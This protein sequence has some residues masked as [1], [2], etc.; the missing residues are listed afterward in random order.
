MTAFAELRCALL[1]LTLVL[2][3][4]APAGAAPVPGT[5]V[6]LEAP[7]GF[8]AAQQFPGF[9]HAESGASIAVSELRAPAA[10]VS[11]G[12]TAEG[13]ATKGM[14]LISAERATIARREARLILVAQ[15]AAG[16]EFQKWIAVFGDGGQTVIL[17]ASFPAAR[18]ASLAGPLKRT[19]LAARWDPTAQVGAFEGLP[20]RVRETA[21]LKITDRLANAILLTAGAAGSPVAPEDPLVVVGTSLGEVEV[22]Q[23]EDF[24]RQRLSQ[25]SQIAGLT[26]LTGKAGTLAGLPAYEL[27]AEAVDRKTGAPLAVYQAL[28]VDGDRYFLVQ[29]LVGRSRAQDFLAQFQDI[30]RSLEV[31]R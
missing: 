17:I 31:V 16:L 2:A 19:L 15:S 3:G 12:F 25:T 29:G 11:A 6:S 14:R 7:Q 24:A 26:A 10:Q 4:G 30:A 21:V 18:A 23:I 5:R 1:V 22:G 13:L 27:V 9:Q 28:A 20:F 8:T